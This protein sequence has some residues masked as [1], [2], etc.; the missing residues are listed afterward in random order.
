MRYFCKDQAGFACSDEPTERLVRRV[1]LN[2]NPPLQESLDP[3]LDVGGDE[4]YL[5]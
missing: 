4:F 2:P 5:D 1:F 3:P